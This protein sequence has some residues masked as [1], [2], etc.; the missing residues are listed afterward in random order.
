MR[1]RSADVVRVLSYAQ[2]LN[3]KLKLSPWVQ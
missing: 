3:C 1:D 2:K